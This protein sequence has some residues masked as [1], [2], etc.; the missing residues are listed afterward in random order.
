MRD[1]GEG[2]WELF[3]RLLDSL[4]KKGVLPGEIGAKTAAEVRF[5]FYYMTT[6]GPLEAV[7]QDVRGIAGGGLALALGDFDWLAEALPRY[8]RS[9]E[10][11]YDKAEHDEVQPESDFPIGAAIAE[12]ATSTVESFPNE[13]TEALETDDAMEVLT[14]AVQAA[15]RDRDAAV[16]LPERRV[17]RRLRRARLRSRPTSRRPMPS[18]TRCASWRSWRARSRTRRRTSVFEQLRDTAPNTTVEFEYY[19]PLLVPKDGKPEDQVFRRTAGG[20]IID[21]GAVAESVFEPRAINRAQAICSEL[22][23]YRPFLW[24]YRDEKLARQKNRAETIRKFGAAVTERIEED[25]LYP[26][27]RRGGRGAHQGRASTQGRGESDPG[28][29]VPRA[30]PGPGRGS[31]REGPERKAAAGGSRRQS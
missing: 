26:A 20:E 13:L 7:A 12:S 29:P 8:R 6:Q 4:S 25:P 28:R 19:V 27:D 23:S 21:H 10:Y 18:A 9:M 16:Q 31:D 30:G 14:L 11:V 22:L 2:T 24:L 1:A 17:P 3:S 15:E 5:G